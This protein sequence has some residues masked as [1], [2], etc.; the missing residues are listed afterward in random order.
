MPNTNRLKGETSPYLLQHAHQ[1]VNWY[2]WGDEA[3]EM[4]RNGKKLVL[5]SIGYAACHWCHVMAHESFDDDE[6]A[7]FMN[8]HF[9]SIKVDREEHPD[10]DQYYMDA[11]QLLTGQ[12]GWPL[13]CFALPDGTPVFGGTYFPKDRW[14]YLMQSLVRTHKQQSHQIKDLATKLQEGMKKQLPQ[15]NATP[16]DTWGS[17][18]LLHTIAQMEAYFDHEKG[19][20]KG[21]PKF[22]LPS[23][24]LPLITFYKDL[25][26]NFSNFLKTSLTQMAT[27]AIFDHL[28]GGFARYSVDENWFVPHFEK[29]LYDNAQLISIYSQTT[30][31]TKIPYF[32]HVGEHA[33]AFL[34]NELKHESGLY[35]ASLD[36]DSEGEEGAYYAWTKQELE[37][38]LGDLFPAF[39]LRYGISEEGN[40]E[41][42]KNLLHIAMSTTDVAKERK[43]GRRSVHMQLQYS[44]DL[45][46]DERKKRTAP[47]KDTKVLTAWNAL[48]VA[49]LVDLSKGTRIT[50]YLDRAREMMDT[51]W[52]VSFTNE[53]QVKRVLF[54]DK[55]IAGNLED[56]AYL[57]YALVKL[58]ETT[59]LPDY[60]FKAKEIAELAID[61]FWD[62][63][64]KLFQ[65]GHGEHPVDLMP[66]YP[67]SDNVLPSANAVLAHVLKVLG[68][69]FEAPTFSLKSGRMHSS[70]RKHIEKI[71]VYGGFWMSSA[72]ISNKPSEVA[73][74]GPESDLAYSKLKSSIPRST[75]VLL[76]NRKEAL[77][78]VKNRWTSDNN[79]HIYICYSG[80]CKTPKTSIEVASDELEASGN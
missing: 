14:L 43:R 7:S 21:A 22:P 52:Q 9:V 29:M 57:S 80:V 56:Y 1:P 68:F 44:L 59:Y 70:A 2:P 55:K 46:R 34:N 38:V 24:Y 69:V 65:L 58:Y 35:F 8:Q 31:V 17:K 51:L 73:I 74:V 41:D 66:S 37:S 32:A 30:E 78:W 64:R 63:K 77:P 20:V 40:W 62:E 48:L 45:L 5:I 19:S 26:E 50:S 13:N 27:G 25:P 61:R 39:A 67:I 23:L 36:A 12:G 60:A 4:A 49:A 76:A 53:K 28:G 47:A 79:T 10:V 33:F 6:V 11:V 75:T 71:P 15:G 42:G 54:T 16:P 3:F 18:D 72:N